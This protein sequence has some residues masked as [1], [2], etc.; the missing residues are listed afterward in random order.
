MTPLQDLPSTEDY[1]PRRNPLILPSEEAKKLFLHYRGSET[2]KKHPQS[3]D[4]LRLDH[5]S[6][7]LRYV[8]PFVL[9]FLQSPKEKRKSGRIH[10]ST[11]PFD[12]I[13]YCLP[14]IEELGYCLKNN[15]NSLKFSTIDFGLCLRSLEGPNQVIAED[16]AD[17]INSR[18]GSF[19]F[20]VMI[21]LRG[22]HLKQLPGSNYDSLG[23]RITDKTQIIHSPV[24]N[25]PGYFSFD[26]FDE[27]TCLPK[28]TE[29]ERKN[30]DLELITHNT[31]LTR[32]YINLYGNIDCGHPD[33]GIADSSSTLFVVKK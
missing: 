3:L 29:T 5:D 26:E 2:M 8:N 4:T 11:S 14:K 15:R 31:G 24:L 18:Y 21:S 16:L 22:T 17:Q 20:P 19:K 1:E 33:L 9:A 23:F 25:Q 32:A 7:A 28:K 6:G 30:H 10:L 13:D 12:R 27:K